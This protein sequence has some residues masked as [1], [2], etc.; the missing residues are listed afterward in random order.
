MQLLWI[1]LLT[2]VL[3]A[4]ALAAE[5]PEG[6][7]MRRQPRSP[8]AP[9]AG[10]P[11]LLDYSRQGAL[12]AAGTLGGY[13]YGLARHGA[14]P[15]ASGIAFN[16]LMLGQM[17]HAWGCRSRA[18]HAAESKGRFL[19]AALGGSLALQGLANW[20]PGLRRLLGL[21]GAVDA[22]DIAAMLAGAGLPHLCNEALR[23][24]ARLK[25]DAAGPE[26]ATNT[27]AASAARSL[28]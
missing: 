8:D 12:L 28:R 16:T 15:A 25:K 18:G 24:Q 2:D 6:D 11:Q 22:L 19:G 26:Q 4:V 21:P 1:N 5:P 13:V 10:K 3:P 17:L 27:Q 14:G 9:I 23:A 7:V 20:L